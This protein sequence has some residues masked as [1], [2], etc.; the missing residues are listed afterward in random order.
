[1]WSL[2]KEKLHKYTLRQWW[3]C[4]SSSH[5]V[6]GQTLNIESSLLNPAKQGTNPV[7]LICKSRI[8]ITLFYSKTSQIFEFVKPQPAC[9]ANAGDV[10]RFV[11]IIPQN[12]V[13]SIKNLLPNTAL[14]CTLRASFSLKSGKE[15]NPNLKENTVP[16]LKYF[17]SHSQT[18]V[19]HLWKHT[20]MKILERGKIIIKKSL[21]L[22]S[23]KF[24]QNFLTHADYFRI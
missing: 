10:L 18:N 12:Q 8:L 6:W 20:F 1:M 23:F 16:T 2:F 19:F 9:L 4:G 24:W 14:V 21:K 13:N 5:Q 3:T 7:C 17:N 11:G 22:I 15:K